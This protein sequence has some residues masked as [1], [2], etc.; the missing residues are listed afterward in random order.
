MRNA[1]SS[2]RS[3][4]EFYTDFLFTLPNAVSKMLS[5]GSRW[6]SGRP[7]VPIF[8]TGMGAARK[9]YRPVTQQK[10]VDGDGVV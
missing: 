9:Q 5:P 2:K 3:G 1:D 7:I 8:K 4:L 6:A 10:D